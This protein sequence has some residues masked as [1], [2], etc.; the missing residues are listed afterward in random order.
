MSQARCNAERQAD[1]K[2]FAVN[3]SLVRAD[4]NRQNAADQADDLPDPATSHAVRVY[5]AVLG[6]IA[7]V[8]ATPLP[9]K[10]LA[11]NAAIA[12]AGSQL[13]ILRVMAS[14]LAILKQMKGRSYA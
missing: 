3:D 9:P 5:L 1:G 2:C 14:D 11:K 4:V 7:F 13:P 12:K 8:C 10:Q 6:A